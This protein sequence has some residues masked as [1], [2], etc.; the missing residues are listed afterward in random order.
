MRKT[1]WEEV[2][3]VVGFPLSGSFYRTMGETAER[4][5]SLLLR[6]SFSSVLS[7][8]EPTKGPH[9]LGLSPMHTRV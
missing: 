9:M 3:K 1:E 7:W 6:L 8:A 2:G 5:R 4:L